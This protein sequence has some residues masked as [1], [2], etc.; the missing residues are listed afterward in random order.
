M[1]LYAF[2]ATLDNPHRTHADSPIVQVVHRP[3]IEKR[4]RES[5]AN[6]AGEK[7]STFC[8]AARAKSSNLAGNSIESKAEHIPKENL[9]L[10]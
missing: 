2:E 3:G 7:W 9:R 4:D 10:P 8:N 5:K 6:P 1:Q